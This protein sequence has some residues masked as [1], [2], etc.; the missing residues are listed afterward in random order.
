M[1]KYVVT[2]DLFTL[3]Y[4]EDNSILYAPRVGFACLANQDLL[5]FITNLE[6]LQQE[7]LSEEQKGVV[8][9]LQEKQIINGT[10]EANCIARLPEKYTPTQ[11]TLFATNKCNMRCKYCY[12]AAGEFTPL[13]MEFKT[14]TDVIDCVL[15]NIK[16]TGR[17]TFQLGFH[18]GGEPLYPWA[19][20]KKIVYYAEEQCQKN[21][22]GLNVYA[23]T[24]GVLNE[25]QLE[26]IIKHFSNLNISFDGLPHVQDHHR[27]MPNGKGSFE[28]VDHTM[29]YL[30]E[31]KFNYAIRSTVSSYNVELMKETIHF[32]GQNYKS[33]LV[34]FEP[35]FYCGRCKTNDLMQPDFEQFA[36]NFLSCDSICDPY[37][38]KVTY[39]GGQIQHLRNSFCGTTRD[40]FAV[41][42]DGYI[43]TCFEVTSKDD[44]KSETFFIGRITEDGEIEVD[45]KKRA[46]LNSLTVD[47][48]EYCKDCF[49]KW[50]CAGDCVVK[51]GHENYAGAR[52]HERCALN[53]QILSHRLEKLVE[54]N[55]S[56]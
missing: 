38:I 1:D 21:G 29:R 3:P 14:A 12:A 56:T 55:Q 51:L 17:P 15:E 30:D 16:K 4:K 50:H 10:N 48:L 49:A 42:P 13:T 36:D 26:W 19:L 32:I 33:K 8:N 22:L 11:V 18:G 45:E 34:H 47:K 46:Y 53:R 52:G 37:N 31:H 5:N 9:Y 2:T 40:N 41:T 44:P 25:E 6:T 39:S 23:A 43:T 35:L 7:E 28:F 20:I 24:N 54:G 27:P